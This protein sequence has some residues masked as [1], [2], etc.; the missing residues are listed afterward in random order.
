MRQKLNKYQLWVFL[1]LIVVEAASFLFIPSK[2]IL[3]LCVDLVVFLL[4]VL[5]LYSATYKE[6]D[7]NDTFH[8][9]SF[10]K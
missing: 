10:H 7:S 9:G 4:A 3:R 5:F 8:K 6:K 2:T 1:S